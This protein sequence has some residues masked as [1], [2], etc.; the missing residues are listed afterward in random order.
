M[1]TLKSAIEL[2]QVFDRL[3]VAE[4]SGISPAEMRKLEEQ[5]A[6]QGLRTMWKVRHTDSPSFRPQSVYSFSGCQVGGR[7]GHP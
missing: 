4:Q 1:S 5:A 6:E 2:K 7:I 3:Q